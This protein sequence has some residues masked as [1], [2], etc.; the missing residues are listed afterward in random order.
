[1]SAATHQRPMY[2]HGVERN[3]FTFTF[4]FTFTP[5]Y[6]KTETEMVNFISY[7]YNNSFYFHRSQDTGHTTQ[8]VI[9]HCLI[10]LLP[11]KFKERLSFA[12]NGAG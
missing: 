4:T 8:A 7:M 10:G 12:T 5:T 9:V 3:I 6:R 11:S 2:L 1:M